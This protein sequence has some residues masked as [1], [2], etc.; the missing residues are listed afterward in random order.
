MRPPKK[1]T[2]SYSGPSAFGQRVSPHAKH[3]LQAFQLCMLW[4]LLFGYVSL[5]L[6]FNRGIPAPPV[7]FFPWRSFPLPVAGTPFPR[8][9]RHLAPLFPKNVLSLFFAQERS[10]FSRRPPK[11]LFLLLCF[12][13]PCVLDDTT[14]SP[15]RGTFLGDETFPLSQDLFSLFSFF[16]LFFLL[17]SFTPGLPLLAPLRETVLFPFSTRILS[18]PSFEASSLFNLY[19]F[20]QPFFFYQSEFPSRRS[21]FSSL[22][23]PPLKRNPCKMFLLHEG[24]A[25]LSS[26]FL[27][28]LV[29]S[30]GIPTPFSTHAP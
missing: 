18:L 22:S 4:E 17:K 30:K 7:S 10:F 19:I 15:S 25:F 23:I 26:P 16:Q 6:F 5:S 12:P 29:E 13:G 24:P 14:F 21:I 9:G 3:L 27:F 2:L 8:L 11:L 20:L 1:T 28:I